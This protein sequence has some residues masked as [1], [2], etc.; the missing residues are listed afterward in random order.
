MQGRSIPDL[1]MDVVAQ[2]ATLLRKEGELARTE[3]SEKVTQIATA[4][5]LIVAGAVLLTP[6][7]VILLQ[8]AVGAL[9]NAGLSQPLAA[10]AIGGGVL[11]I[12][13]ILTAIGIS[14]FKADRLVPHKTIHQLQRDVTVAKEQAGTDYERQQAA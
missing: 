2:L 9:V 5:G 8:A 4:M 14:R 6:A 1:F 13:A 12:G 11:I 3:L 10:V 7:L